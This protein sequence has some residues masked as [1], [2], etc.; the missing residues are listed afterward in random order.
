M[1]RLS[2]W[3]LFMVIFLLTAFS[4]FAQDATTKATEATATELAAPASSAGVANAVADANVPL[5]E[6]ALDKQLKEIGSK[7]DTLKEDSF[8]TKSRLL[9]L[10]EEVLRRSMSG[11]RLAIVHKNAMGGQYELV[12][13]NYV[14]DNE[15]KY[16]RQDDTGTLDKLD[17]EVIY[18]GVL[19]P[20][21]H[22]LS[23]SFVYKGKAWGVFRYM[24]GY[25][26]RVSSGYSFSVEEGKSVE[27]TVSAME[28]GNFFTAY[29]ERP[30]I[31]FE[32]MQF[33][34][35]REEPAS[36]KKKAASGNTS[37]ANKS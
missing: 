33:D 6:A 30:D 7:V 8:T 26:F 27:L 34:L 21:T 15:P 36:D 13:I 14:V 23:V 19:A 10:R 16:T 3:S 35:L 2:I 28:R 31:S 17:N 12:Q 11:S 32:F 4:A 5:D 18:E 29:E 20:G 24:K 25:T 1:H 22:Q 37:T 9:L